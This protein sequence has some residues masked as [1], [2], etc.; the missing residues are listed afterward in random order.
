MVKN[1]R[2]RSENI[3]ENYRTVGGVSDNFSD[4]CCRQESETKTVRLLPT[5]F[6][7]RVLVIVTI[8]FSVFAENP[9]KRKPDQ[10]VN[11][12]TNTRDISVYTIIAIIRIKS[13]LIRTSSVVGAVVLV[14]RVICEN[15]RTHDSG[16]V[17]L[18]FSTAV[19]SDSTAVANIQK[20]VKSSHCCFLK[21]YQNSRT[22]KIYIPNLT[23]V[24]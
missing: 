17:H 10:T 5:R 15:Q 21:K 8:N 24:R 6:I 7:Y 11:R 20:V 1:K 16:S 12:T 13:Y 4:Y 23:I 14:R 19:A 2:K 18:F 22:N 3:R 9:G